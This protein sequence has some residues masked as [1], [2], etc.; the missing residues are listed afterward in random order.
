MQTHYTVVKFLIQYITQYGVPRYITSDRGLHFK[1]K[2]MNDAC[3]NF[4]IK[5]IFSSSYAPQSQGFTERIN[6]VICQAIRH[7]IKN[8][9]QSRWSFYL[10]YIIFSYNNS[11]KISKKYSPYYLLHG[12][13]ANIGIDTQITPENLSYDFK[14]SLE[15][16]KQV[17]ENI[18][19]Y[20]KKAQN[21]QKINH[22][23]LHKL[24]TYEPNQLVLVKFPFQE[25]NK[26][27][28]LAP[29]YRGP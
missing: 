17:R 13:N 28:K 29:K 7:Y 19:E 8:N 10:P 9:N 4:G 16:I 15:E 22:D 23:K 20:I 1:N 6:G 25:P 12:F 14:K 3:A 5:Q 26:T 18:P 11:P 24:T 21:T 2:I 27:S